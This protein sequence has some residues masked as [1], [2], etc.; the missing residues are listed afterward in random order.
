MFFGIDMN[1]D[2]I[3]FLAYLCLNLVVGLR[4]GRN[5][6][7]IQDYALGGRNFTTGA[8]VATIVGT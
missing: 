7:T 1:I 6:K 3:L 5:V 4:Y 2:I 8:L